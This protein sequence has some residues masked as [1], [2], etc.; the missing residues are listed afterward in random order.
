MPTTTTAQDPALARIIAVARDRF[1]TKARIKR[2]TFIPALA[3]AAVAAAVAQ[4]TLLSPAAHGQRAPRI[5]TDVRDHV[6]GCDNNDNDDC[7]NYA[8]DVTESSEREPGFESGVNVGCS[9]A[10]R[11][12]LNVG[13][14]CSY[15]HEGRSPRVECLEAVDATLSNLARHR[16]FIEAL[17]L[18]AS[19]LEAMVNCGHFAY[20]R[21]APSA[22]G[23]SPSVYELE[24]YDRAPRAPR[25]VDVLR[26]VSFTVSAAGVSSFTPASPPTE[27]ASQGATHRGDK[28]LILAPLQLLTAPAVDFTPIA[29]WEREVR[30]F[31]ALRRVPVVRTFRMWKGLA[32]WR[33]NV[34][35]KK[36]C[37]AAAAVGTQL[38]GTDA[39]LG[40]AL[41]QVRALSIAIADVE[42]FALPTKSSVAADARMLEAFV[43]EQAARRSDATVQLAAIAKNV[44]TIVRSACDDILEA[45]LAAH[46]IAAD[47]RMSF[48]ERAA[49]RNECRRLVRFVT[50]ADMHIADA[51]LARALTAAA[52]LAQAIAPPL[53][54]EART[55]LLVLV[56]GGWGARD[57]K[58]GSGHKTDAEGPSSIARSRQL[59]VAVADRV[60]LAKLPVPASNDAYDACADVIEF[61]DPTLVLSPSLDETRAMLRRVLDAAILVISRS[62]RLRSNAMIAPYIAA[63]A[64]DPDAAAAAALR[65]SADSAVGGDDRDGVGGGDLA[66]AVA[67][68]ATFRT[69]AAELSRGVDIAY[70]A[71]VACCAALVSGARVIAHAATATAPLHLAA[72]Y[73]NSAPPARFAADIATFRRMEIDAQALPVAFDV[74]VVRLDSATLRS[75]ALPASRT[76]LSAI[77][78]ALPPLITAGIERGVMNAR[79]LATVLSS[80]TP[81]VETFLGQVD[82]LEESYELLRVTRSEEVRLRAL[83]TLMTANGWPLA[84]SLR[85]GFRTLRSALEEADTAADAADACLDDN[86]KQFGIMAAAAIPAI[87]D[88]VAEVSAHLRE[89]AATEPGT[90]APRVQRLLRDATVA[91]TSLRESAAGAT[92]H[93]ERL[94]L[95]P[96]PTLEASH[97]V[98]VA[99]VE[100]GHLR[101]LWDGSST[102]A[103]AAEA[104]LLVPLAS[105]SLRELTSD[106]VNVEALVDESMATYL[107]VPNGVGAALRADVMRWRA[108]LPLITALRSP[109]LL[110]IHWERI[111]TELGMHVDAAVRSYT[112]DVQIISLGSKTVAVL[113]DLP[114]PAASPPLLV[115]MLTTPTGVSTLNVLGDLLRLTELRAV[116]VAVSSIAAAAAVEATMAQQYSAQVAAP[117]ADMELQVLPYFRAHDVGPAVR[118]VFILGPLDAV[119]AALAVA[120]RVISGICASPDCPSALRTSAE[121]MARRLDAVDSTLLA[122]F[123]FQEAWAPLE[124]RFHGPECEALSG[125]APEAARVFAA[126]DRVWRALMKRTAAVPRV[127]SAAGAAGLALTLQRNVDAL[128]EAAGLLAAHDALEVNRNAPGHPAAD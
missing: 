127:L 2:E 80:T 92:F 14:S 101:A 5:V 17:S 27:P 121:T 120:L 58:R 49:L 116:A 85:A 122:W 11:A 93:A 55:P 39:T 77:A 22:R 112:T 51:L 73:N 33:T 42:L 79:R 88:G 57:G 76:C 45:F 38:F 16:T 10:A 12:L 109:H 67:A 86:V 68:H 19:K 69:C 30:I 23:R 59:H 128:A 13:H 95:P 24:Y 7:S 6:H 105:V 65:A 87:L 26:Q 61:L 113:G 64:V 84:D 32:L 62:P 125:A 103:V 104:W 18:P 50:V 119:H 54:G 98:D 52:E 75:A 20:A 115:P 70:A 29:Q 81:D 34:T 37:A 118:D 21:Y 124:S 111:E 1:A 89:R 82:A 46:N 91:L 96:Q 25:D 47:V 36:R 110:P 94:R 78:A 107:G 28:P 15:I 43:T 90:P 8:A 102:W 56:I 108:V 72:R 3:A 40:P 41:L 53:R 97:A 74:G 31:H 63:A 48:M 106:I 123:R 35:R 99:A 9:A 83:G 71:A 4:R 66:V 44:C 60:A 114:M 126:V 117:W 100:L